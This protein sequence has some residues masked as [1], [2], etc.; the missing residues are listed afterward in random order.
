[1][2]PIED[3]VDL[4]LVGLAMPSRFSLIGTSWSG[5]F[6]IIFVLN[7]A[8]VVWI[9]GSVTFFCCSPAVEIVWFFSYAFGT[10]RSELEKEPLPIA[11]LVGREGL[12]PIAKEPENLFWVEPGLRWEAFAPD[13]E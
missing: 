5:T 6:P 10:P 11:V 8:L 12:L 1:M 13:E 7:W 4:E 3:F 9:S 2:A